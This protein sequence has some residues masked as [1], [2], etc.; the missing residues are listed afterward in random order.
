MTNFCNKLRFACR[1]GRMLLLCTFVL[2]AA[3]AA[4]QQRVVSGKVVDQNGQPL[5]GVAVIE[6][7]TTN[8][9]TTNA[10]G[11][12]ALNIKGGGKCKP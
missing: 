3:S 11:S 4:A 7:G 9:T 2:A 5:I 10:D 6:S 1:A 12:Y 8:G